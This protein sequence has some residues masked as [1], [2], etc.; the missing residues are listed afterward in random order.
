MR[1]ETRWLLATMLVLACGQ[2][3]AVKPFEIDALETDELRLLYFDPFHTY[4]KPHL[5]RTYEN[6]VQFHKQIFNWEPYDRPTIVLQ[7]FIDYGGGAAVPSPYNLV[8]I[9]VAPK[10]HTLETTPGNERFFMLM[11]HEMTHIATMDV[12]NQQDLRWRRFFGG[13]V[14]Q[15]ND[16]PESIL[17]N[18]LTV[19]RL[20]T[21]R[22]YGEGS[23]VFMETW[24]SGGIGRSQGAYDEM[25]FRAMVRDDAP[26]YSNLGLVS[27][28]TEVDFQ[29][30]ANAYLYGTRFFGYLAWQYS[31]EQVIEWLSRNEDSERYYAAQFRHV[32]GKDLEDAWQDWIGFEHSF[33]QENLARVRGVPL[34]PATPLAPEALGSVSRSFIDPAT[35][36][37]LGGF[38]YPGVV[39]HIGA[40]SLDTGQT[41][42]LVDIKGPMLYRV[43]STAFDPGS[44]TL[45]YTTDNNAYRDLVAL[46]LATGKDRLLIKDGRIGDLAF[47]NS[48]GILWGLRHLNGYVTLV[49]MAPPYTEWNQVHT[50]EHGQVA[51][52][53][54]VSPDGQLLAVTVAEVNGDQY[55]RVFR[56]ADMGGE[57]PQP[58]G[59]FDFG[60]AIPEGFVFS[61]DGRYLFGSSYYT[62]ASNIFRYELAT[63][64]LE[65]VSNAETG[66][67]RPIPQADG[68]L[69]AFE[70]TGEGFMPVRIDPVPLDDV[71]SIIF[72]GNEIVKKHPVVRDWSVV[73]SLRDQQYEEIITAEYKYR[74]Y[75]HLG[76]TSGYPVLMGYRD[77]LALGYTFR[78]SDPTTLH[79]FDITAGYSWD[80]PSDEEFHFDVRYEAVNWWLRYWHNFAD[81]YDL[82]GPTERARKGDAFFVGYD[83][84]LI[85]DLPRRL[86]FYAEVAYYTGLDTLPNNQNRP[87]F[88]ID[89]ILAAKAGLEF[90][91]TDKSLGAVDHEK[92]WRWRAESRVDHSEFDTIPK[93]RGGI[94]FGFALPWRHASVWFY[95]H[96]GWADGDRLD[97]LTNYYFGGFGNNYV[98]DREV[99]R[100][101][102]YYSMPGFEIDEIGGREFGKVTAEFNFPPIRFREAGKP[103]LFLKHIRPSI[104]ASGLITD[105]GEI[106]ERTT[107]SLGFQLDLEFTLVHRLPMT[108]SVG[109]GAGY[110]SGDK[111]DDEWMVSLKIL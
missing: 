56:V 54:D 61:P 12:S 108:L 4:L 106:I 40:L 65:A 109:W 71:S 51:F 79:H 37:L 75:R 104:F 26:F 66:F 81:F 101:R 43:T 48:D 80:S 8:L 47:S 36:E 86:D 98:D 95:N 6:S 10:N 13:K 24:M 90:E 5:T 33:Q 78:V 58:V 92:G 39:A 74:P 103:G 27:E 9:D 70:Y 42:R 62:G 53:L 16:H 52:E 60:H 67:F 77:D 102:E 82:F 85:Y 84:P 50:W 17:F 41:R 94:D 20:S 107:T 49:R 30:G 91:H 87:T 69:V 18:Y 105:P 23:A 64:E 44:R 28:G 55:L 63:G 100:Y 46:D 29:V 1:H 83:R 38:R 89:K 72:L 97:P 14:Q 34:T 96:L 45:F 59:S 21:P 68:S 110:E 88:F 7:D 11:N 25:V 99:K 32:F 3:Q 31:P 15:T 35:N 19:P 111:R 76:F 57:D 2:A 93:L 73:G 22:W